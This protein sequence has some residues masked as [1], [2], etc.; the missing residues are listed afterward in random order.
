MKDKWTA[1]WGRCWKSCTKALKEEFGCR[2]SSFSTLYFSNYMTSEL[3]LVQ[4]VAHIGSCIYRLSPPHR[5]FGFSHNSQRR[6]HDRANAPLL[7]NRPQSFFLF[8]FNLLHLYNMWLYRDFKD[9][10]K[11]FL[12]STL[13]SL[14]WQHE[15]WRLYWHSRP[16]VSSL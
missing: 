3:K 6:F 12:L 8:F 1:G 4:R 9:E 16:N 15:G 7:R 11:G 10:N 5:H 14:Q 2:L 13:E